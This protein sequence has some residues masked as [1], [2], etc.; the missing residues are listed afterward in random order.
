M[1]GPDSYPSFDCQSVQERFHRLHMMRDA[2]TGSSE[3]SIPPSS[4]EGA[5]VVTG[6]SFE[7]AGAESS[8]TGVNT[9][10]GSQLTINVKG[11]AE[12]TVVHAILYYE[13]VCNSSSAGVGILD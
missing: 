10:A 11:L 9:R 6:Q 12:A 7:K 8:H 4:Y 2:Q 1:L 13:Q 5:N 3:M